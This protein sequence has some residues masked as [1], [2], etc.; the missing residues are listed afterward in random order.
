MQSR[1]H[2]HYLFRDITHFLKK[3]QG[4]SDSLPTKYLQSLPVLY[5]S[6]S[7]SMGPRPAAA[8][9]GNLKE[10]QIPS[11]CLRPTESETLGVGPA[12]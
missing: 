3:N 12:I 6:D 4:F 10:M 7:Q 8:A 1:D 2:Y 11:S 5:A 9:P